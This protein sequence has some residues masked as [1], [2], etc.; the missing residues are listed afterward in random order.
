[1]RS[2]S[3]LKLPNN[4]KVNFCCLLLCITCF[5]ISVKCQAPEILWEH[6]YGGAED[7]RAMHILK[8]FDLNYLIVGYGNSVDGDFT[9][10]HGS[11]DINIVKTNT[12]GEVIW[13]RSYGGSNIEYAYSACQA[14]DSGYI[15]AGKSYSFDG[16]LTG[17]NGNSDMW[18][19]KIN[20]S[21]DIIWQFNYGGTHNETP[22]SIIQTGDGGYMIT[23]S[24]Q[25]NDGDV[26]GHHGASGVRDI[27]LLKLDQS[28]NLVWNKCLGSTGTDDS[29]QIISTLDGN[30]IL[31]GDTNGSDGDINFT[32]GDYDVIAI[33]ISP[34]GEIIWSKNY[35]GSWPDYG[36]SVKELP[37]GNLLF[38]ADTQ[39][40]DGLVEG[41]HDVTDV[42][43]FKTD[44]EGNFLW[45]RAYGGSW[46]DNGTDVI[47][48]NENHYII[49]AAASVD[50]GDIEFLHDGT[51][52]WAFGV[53]SLGNILWQKGI[54]GSLNDFPNS[55]LKVNDEEFLISGYSNSVDFDVTPTYASYNMWTAKLA[56]CN[57][58]Y[59]ADY[60]ED[61]YGNIDWQVI[62]CLPPDGFILDSTD[63]NDF[64]A[65]IHPFVA[66]VCNTI[67]DNCNG[68][69]DEDA[70]FTTYYADADGDTFGDA[71]MDTSI[72]SILVGFVENNLD[73]Q[74]AD[75]F[76]NP[77]ST[78]ICNAIDDDC[79]TLIDDGLL[80][81]TLFADADGDT[82]GDIN[83]DT[84]VC[85]D[86]AGFISDSADCDDTNPYIF[87]GA[88]ELLNGV[89]DDCD[90][91]ADE[92]LTV[93][94]AALTI[95]IYPNPT[96]NQVM[97]AYPFEAPYEI[98]LFDAIGQLIFKEF[99]YDANWQLS[100]EGYA[101]GIYTI[102]ITSEQ[103]GFVTQVVKE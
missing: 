60:D 91:L 49:T 82:Y 103:I 101:A 67:D 44:A 90:Q 57:T 27:W 93:E 31:I 86:I 38:L 61:G 39:S 36:R 42:W 17:N 23:G 76:I 102:S 37:D 15:I 8:T 83:T 25:S 18:I 89:D 24:S 47:A 21:G 56:F 6:G 13:T 64:D 78:E 46:V 12:Y 92:G 52:I 75:A 26:I 85:M 81:Y 41:Y 100:M 77:A 96:L 99:V 14:I 29:E 7:D 68:L 3:K 5:S 53:D 1:M 65:D 48:F 73:C 34:E 22:G 51:D 43:L 50:D 58:T 2:N 88:A 72:C 11:L 19:F 94:T 97:I 71:L 95:S 59:Y 62:A 80:F 28:G 74:D 30:F 45:G 4:L 79:N 87:P 63:C 16:D 55:I 69:T 70:L 66:D 20:E 98:N 84:I 35:G 10:N 40:D 32:Y 54:G 9:G 33:K